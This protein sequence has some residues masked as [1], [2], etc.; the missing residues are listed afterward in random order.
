LAKVN[1]IHRNTINTAT[2]NKKKRGGC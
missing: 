2:K 1:T